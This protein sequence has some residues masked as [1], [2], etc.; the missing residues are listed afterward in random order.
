MAISIFVIKKYYKILSGNS[1]FTVNQD[2]GKFYSKTDVKGYYNNLTEKITRF[3]NPGNE[4]PITYVAKNMKIHFSIEIF[5]YGLAAF[6]LYLETNKNDYLKKF[7][8]C[9]DW[10][11]SN[12]DEKGRWETFPYKRDDQLFSSMA[13]GE[14]IS[15]LTRA[16]ILWGDEKYKIAAK[17]SKEFMLTSVDKGGTSVI[18]DGKIYLYE[19]INEDLVLNGW[20]FS[21]WGLYDYAKCFNDKEAWTQWANTVDAMAEKLP[22]YDRRIW[23]SYTDGKKWA[24][25]FYHKLHIAQ[26]NVMYDLTDIITFKIYA[27]K[28]QKYQNNRCYRI[29]AFF[30]KIWQKAIDNS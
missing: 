24:N 5:Q 26:L 27:D 21:A 16:Y 12:Q 3:G 1:V 15:L 28:F 4:L 25:P 2:E 19:Y 9:V 14:A 17:K 23:S 22:V 11:I 30:Y 18:K 10:A 29:I 13:Q 7:Q 6:D 8:A 20:I